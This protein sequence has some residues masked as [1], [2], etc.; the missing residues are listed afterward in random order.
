MEKKT[1]CISLILILLLNIS[2]F[3]QVQK[4]TDCRS[5]Q[6]PLF[7]YKGDTLVNTCDTVVLI[8]VVRYHLYETSR[9]SVLNNNYSKLQNEM[10]S[11]LLEQISLYKEWNDSLQHQYTTVSNMFAA[12]LNTT[13]NQLGKVSGEI[14]AAQVSLDAA[15]KNLDEAVKHLKKAQWDKYKWGGVGL[16]VGVLVSTLVFVAH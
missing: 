2:A 16:L 14:N 7:L 3:S 10:N 11:A 9:Q 4:F 6:K 12:S 8:N 15:N 5:F 1:L 13:Q